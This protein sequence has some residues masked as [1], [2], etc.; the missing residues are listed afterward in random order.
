MK[1]L[2][3]SV[4]GFKNFRAEIVWRRTNAKGLAFKGY[5]KNHDIIFYYINGDNYQWNRVFGEYD[6]K[7]IADFYRYVEEGSGRRY[8]LSDLTN[9]NH[10]R[11]NL[12][13]EWHGHTKVWRWTKERMQEAESKGLIHYTSSGLARQKRY[14]DEM[15]GNPIDTIWEDIPPIQAQSKERLGYPTQKPEALL[16]RIISASSNEGDLILDPFCGCGTTVAVAERLKRRWIGIDITY[17]AIALMKTRLQDTFTGDLSPYE[18]IG[19]PKDLSG[20]QALAQESRYQFEWWAVAKVGAYPA[21]DKKKGADHGIDGIIKF[22][23]DDSGKHKKIVIQVKSGLHVKVGDIRDLIGVVKRESAAIGVFITLTE[24]TDP[25]RTE[26]IKE[27]FYTSEFLGKDNKY[28]KIQILT[29]ADILGGSSIKYPR[30]GDITFKKA[31]TQPK[32]DGQE[33]CF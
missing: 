28:P 32:I 30:S 9:P 4:F 6:P 27:G 5:P 23:D 11:P 17:L 21:Q 18:V 16:E 15:Q 19:D 33:S 8:C 7:Y 2:L 24:S 31:A 1:L 20:A 25:M 26:A 10:N 13:Y 14:L 22:R 3:D 12:T 29:I